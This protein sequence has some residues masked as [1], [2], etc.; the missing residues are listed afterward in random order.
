MLEAATT[1]IEVDPSGWM[2][3]ARMSA[4][5]FWTNHSFPRARLH[6][7]RAIELDP[8]ASMAYHFSGCIYGFA[9]DLPAAIETEGHAHRVDPEY[10]HA[11]VVEADLG[12]WSL[13]AAISTAWRSTCI[14]RSTWSRS[15]SAGPSLTR[16][17]RG[18]LPEEDF[19]RSSIAWNSSAGMGLPKWYPWA[20]S[21]P[22]SRR[23]SS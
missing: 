14:A 5:E 16:Q 23:Y 8:T 2:G 19:C 9:G 11:D 21:H 17:P 18:T 4:G 22:F 1:S 3:H 12:L 10:P 15:D 7:D 20:L 6:A 13:L